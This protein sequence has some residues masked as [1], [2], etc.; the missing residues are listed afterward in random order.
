MKFLGADEYLEWPI[1]H[2][3]DGF[4]RFPRNSKSTVP[5]KIAG[6]AAPVLMIEVLTGCYS[7]RNHAISQ[8][9]AFLRHN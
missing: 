4:F 6:I 8:V 5:N 7:W 9:C 1:S 3:S 2:F